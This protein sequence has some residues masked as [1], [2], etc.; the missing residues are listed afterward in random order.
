MIYFPFECGGS[1][2]F[3]LLIL[4]LDP[5]EVGHYDQNSVVLLESKCNQEMLYGKVSKP[6]GLL[7]QISTKIEAV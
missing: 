6:M 7:P 1:L 4:D 3:S 2:V 5:K